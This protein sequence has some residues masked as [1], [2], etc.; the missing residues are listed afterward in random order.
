MVAETPIFGTAIELFLREMT[1]KI[2]EHIKGSNVSHKSIFSPL[3]PEAR[4]EAPAA[5]RVSRTVA[6]ADVAN[7]SLQ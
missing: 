6:V 4:R 7:M 5:S 2:E 1:T 3:Y